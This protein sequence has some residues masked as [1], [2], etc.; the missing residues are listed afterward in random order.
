MEAEP[1]SRL[2]SSGRGSFSPD[3]KLLR[4][5]K[6]HTIQNKKLGQCM[7]WDF[8]GSGGAHVQGLAWRAQAAWIPSWE[9]VRS[10]TWLPSEHVIWAR[11]VRELVCFSLSEKQRNSYP[12]LGSG[13]CVGRE[14]LSQMAD[15]C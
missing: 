14:L 8:L 15:G 5:S 12:T 7:C 13:G 9:S 3:S 2:G 10:V 4:T 1:R 11:E 6:H